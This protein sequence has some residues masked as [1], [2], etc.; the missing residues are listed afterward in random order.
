MFCNYASSHNSKIIGAYDQGIVDYRNGNSAN[1]ISYAGNDKDFL[2][3]FT[4]TL[5]KI[6]GNVLYVFTM[7]VI[8]HVG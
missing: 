8:L 5:N 4:L 3:L 2:E 6:A 1:F 7:P